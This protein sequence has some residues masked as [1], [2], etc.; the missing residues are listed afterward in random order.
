MAMPYN[1]ESSLRHLNTVLKETPLP[2]MTISIICN[3]IP[4]ANLEAWSLVFLHMDPAVG[5]TEAKKQLEIQ[6]GN[7]FKIASAYMT[8]ALNWPVMKPEDGNGLRSYA[9]FLRSCYHTMQDID[10]LRELENSTNLRQIAS[11]LPF[12]LRDKWRVNVCNMQD[13]DKRVT[14]KDLVEFIEKQS[15][16]M[17]DPVFGD[18]SSS[19]TAEAKRFL[20]PKAQTVGSKPNDRTSFATTV[21]HVPDT[22]NNEW[23]LERKQ[24]QQ[25]PNSSAFERPCLFCEKNH[26]F[27]HCELFQSKPNAERIEYLKTN[28]M[29]FGCLIKGHVSR[30]C[31]NRMTCEKCSLSHPTILHIHTGKQKDD[32]KGDHVLPASSAMVSVKDDSW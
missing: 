24:K 25:N 13:Q 20:K 27:E 22:R 10:G 1:I 3:S 9:L 16:A 8:K 32:R 14:Y 28:G 2:W 19:S 12:R 15:R 21:A 4:R 7:R 17:L 18:L 29:C 23:K 31:K 26:T 11:K 5:Y 30:T 6:F